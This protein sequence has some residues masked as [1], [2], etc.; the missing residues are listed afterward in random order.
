MQTYS[1]YKAL[2]VELKTIKDIIEAE[3]M[4]TV[5]GTACK[6][7]V[8]EKLREAC[9]LSEIAQE[10]QFDEVTLAYMLDVFVQAGFLQS[11]A[12]GYR[13]TPLAEIYFVRSSFLYMG[14]QFISGSMKHDI[15]SN[16]MNSLTHAAEQAPGP[17]PDWNPECLRQ[18]GVSSLLGS[19]QDAVAAVSLD[20]ARRLL[21]LG[22]GHGFYSIAFAQRYPE[23]KV[24]LYDLPKVVP[25]ASQFVRNFGME[26]RIQVVEGNFLTDSI[27]TDYDA[28]LCANILHRDKR[29]I[30]LPKVHAALKPGGQLVVKCRVKDGEQ[31]V[32]A[33]L[34]RL[35]W[36]IQG[37]KE[38]LNQNKW[39]KTLEQYGFANVRTVGM[40][41]IFATLVGQ[42]QS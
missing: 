21:D 22:G 3:Q 6:L 30:V 23:L 9:H 27:G 25:L 11:D 42:K 12:D 29:A 31:S 39:W 19:V 14:H 20:S 16:L 32:S 8:F 26:D 4:Y 18:I 28:I 7:H 1:L 2:P 17:E 15:E 40:N 36:H 5:I 37:G 35:L 13:N 34:A 41:G 24:V 38:I 33:A 10:L